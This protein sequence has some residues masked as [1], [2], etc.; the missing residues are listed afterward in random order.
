MQGRES[1]KLRPGNL[2]EPTALNK[3]QGREGLIQ[4]LL[5]E[6]G[7]LTRVWAAPGWTVLPKLDFTVGSEAF[8]G[9][10]STY[11]IMCLGERKHHPFRHRRETLELS[12]EPP[13]SHPHI[14]WVPKLWEFCLLHMS[15]SA[16]P[17]HLKS[18]GKD[19]V[20]ISCPEMQPC[21]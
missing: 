10:C 18:L 11:Y 8:A 14:T 7:N 3:G 12:M 21:P 9:R 20:T 16:T 6:S 2:A 13:L 17:S 15:Q 1:D 5:A 4:C 19:L